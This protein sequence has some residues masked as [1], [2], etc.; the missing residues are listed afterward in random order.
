MMIDT[1]YPEFINIME[2]LTDR[3]VFDYT[4]LLEKCVK[5]VPPKKFTP[6]QTPE[7]IDLK[8]YVI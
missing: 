7:K 2:C 1:K 3:P 4:A 8:D 5:L 6:R